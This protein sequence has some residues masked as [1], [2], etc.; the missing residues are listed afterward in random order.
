[1]LLKLHFRLHSQCEIN[2]GRDHVP[3]ALRE[4][5]HKQD[6]LMKHVG[7][8]NFLYEEF[9]Y[10]LFFICTKNFGRHYPAK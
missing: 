2:D 5:N 6:I 7:Y 1:M 8:F 3:A 4:D 9:I 10:K